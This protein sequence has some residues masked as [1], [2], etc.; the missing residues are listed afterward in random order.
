M[1]EIKFRIWDKE[2]KRFSTMAHEEKFKNVIA[3]ENYIL[4]GSVGITDVFGKEVFD[5]DIIK[6]ERGGTSAMLIIR[7]NDYYNGYR[8][9]EDKHRYGRHIALSDLDTIEVIGN[10]FEDEKL[11][12]EV[13]A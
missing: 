10:V 2:N 3:S 11:L 5:G 12:E 8:A 13:G 1:R 9:Y 7:W 4:V 6:A